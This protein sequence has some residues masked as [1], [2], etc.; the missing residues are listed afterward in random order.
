[1]PIN[2]SMS[3]DVAI[4]R[5]FVENSTNGIWTGYIS[6]IGEGLGYAEST[7]SRTISGMASEGSIIYLERGI[8]GA[9]SKIRIG[10]EPQQTI[11][12]D[13]WSDK[14][15]LLYKKMWTDGVPT[16]EMGR[17]LG[18][19][20]SAITGKR[21]RLG[22][23]PRPSPVKKNADGKSIRAYSGNPQG[24]NAVTPVVFANSR[25]A[26]EDIAKITRPKEI[27]KIVNMSH[28]RPEAVKAAWPRKTTVPETEDT[29][30][31]SVAITQEP[32]APKIAT[33]AKSASALA[34]S[35]TGVVGWS[36]TTLPKPP[37]RK[38]GVCRWPR[39]CDMPGQPWCAEHAALLRGRRSA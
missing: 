17:R 25:A 20:K 23:P 37:A 26:G 18:V 6:K 8:F 14:A 33:R 3:S 13:Q 15:V 12:V 16:E 4:W 29:I 21:Q 10:E 19:S 22:L 11:R 9:L 32:I 35:I 2:P 31:K 24:N 7:I 34:S 39:T 28:M 38:P 36:M 1:M 27:P 5:W 30:R